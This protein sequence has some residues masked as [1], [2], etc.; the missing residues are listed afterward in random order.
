MQ[1]SASGRSKFVETL[2]RFR[3]RRLNGKLVLS[4]LAIGIVPLAVVGWYSTSRAQSSLTEAA[5]QRL[6]VAAIEAADLSDRNLFERYGDV[7]AFAANP[8]ALGTVQERQEIVDFLTA[9]YGIYDLMLIVD[10]EGTVLT[11]NSIDGGGETLNTGRLVGTDV[12]SQEWFR[13]VAGGNTPAGGTYYTDVERNDLV[14]DVYGE[15]LLTLPFTAPIFDSDGQ[16][17]A[18]WHNQASFDR[19]VTDI[20]NSVKDELRDTGVST[21]ETQV[22]RSDGV[23]IDDVSPD[24]IL[25][26]NLIDVGI[27]AAARAV[28]SG[29]GVVQEVHARRGVEQ[30]NGYAKSDGALGFEGYGWGILVRQDVSEATAAAADLRNGIVLVAIVMIVAI[31]AIGYYLARGIAK[32]VAL[33]AAQASKI[34]EG[35][36]SVEKLDI[37]REDEIGDLASSFNEMSTMLKMVGTQAQLIAEKDLTADDLDQH[38]PGQLG[39][40]VSTMIGSLRDMVDQLR[41]SSQQLAGAAEELST[42]SAT[43]GSSAEQTSQQASSASASGDEVSSSVATVAAAIEEMNATI[44]EV[45]A[46]ATEA[47][48]VASEA[49]GTARLTSDTIQKL[50]QSSEEIGTVIGV[51][52]SI[53]EQT[54]LLALNATIEAARAGEAGKGFAVVATEVKELAN[55]T[56]TA[57]EEIALRIQAIQEDMV[58]AVQA[59]EQIGETIDRINE[60]SSI[61][62]AVEEQSVTTAEIGRSI[63]DAATGTQEIATSITEVATAADSTRQSTDDTRRSAE[64]MSRMAS[65]LNELVDEYR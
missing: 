35:D 20:M 46:S 5:G 11:A 3:P 60:I 45:A 53:A 10:L 44:R 55:Q 30:L 2:G 17:V 61:A 4:F 7:Q 18:I 41:G 29:H 38:T 50:G 36:L 32:P 40:A 51:I 34:A 43:M 63:E 27:E 28:D 24:A 22:L 56:G 48:N 6:E 9:T 15:A 25:S 49:V 8:K 54:N 39:D 1:E 12:S 21:V 23:V 19:V 59:N 58:G 62:S 37:E 64:E 33:V 65:E 14:R 42:V 52:N 16:M 26:L 31:A 57:T 47:S 13:I